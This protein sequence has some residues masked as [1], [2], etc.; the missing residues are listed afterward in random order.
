MT[1]E[2]PPGDIAAHIETWNAILAGAQTHG[3]ATRDARDQARDYHTEHLLDWELGQTRQ[4]FLDAH[5]GAA[6]RVDVLVSMVGFSPETTV[7]TAHTLRPRHL[8]LVYSKKSHK[9]LDHIH[10][11]LVARRGVLSPR[12]ITTRLCEA[13]DPA[14]IYKVIHAALDEARHLLDLEPEA[15]SEY[16]DITGGKKVMSATSALV[17]WQLD[18]NICYIDSDI[19]PLT[20]KPAPGSTR[21]IELGNPMTIFGA[22]ELAVGERLFDAGNHGA[23][24]EHF[25]AM[26]RRVTDPGP[27]TARLHLA[28][29][30]AAWSGLD[31]ARLAEFIPRVQTDLRTQRLILGADQL[32]RLEHQLGYLTR[33]VAD[34]DARPRALLA[35]YHMLGGH[36]DDLGRHDFAALLFYRTIESTLQSRLELAHGIDASEPDYAGVTQ[37]AMA[38]WA[39]LNAAIYGAE[40]ASFDQPYKLG[41]MASVVLLAALD[42]PLIARVRLGEV[43]GL[44]NLRRLSDTRN[45]SVLAH[46]HETIQPAQLQQ[47]RHLAGEFVAAIDALHPGEFAGAGSVEGL[48]FIRFG[49]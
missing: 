6:P 36:Y 49:G 41:L 45:R 28:D 9:N 21:V 35:S 17:A 14:D 13:A 12:S 26:S 7:S 20:R 5:G 48:R 38:R 27:A 2:R 24:R 31:F 47:L 25:D 30:Y 44:Q 16:I 33:L 42:D 3:D 19:D 34:T 40:P 32:S 1:T 43:K 8:V 23:A 15:A 37:E 46:G 10:E 39:E 22:E 29:L 11:Q 4:A 18:L